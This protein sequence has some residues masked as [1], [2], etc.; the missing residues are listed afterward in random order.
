MKE[1]YYNSIVM[2]EKL[3]RLFLE[4]LK[5][6]LK[7]LNTND[8]NNIQALVLYN[9][10]EN[11]LSVG[12]LTSHGYYLGSNVSYNLRKMVENGYIMQTLND[13]DRRSSEVKLTQKG[14][15][16]YKKIDV[17]FEQHSKYLNENNIDENTIINL[18]DTLQT[19]ERYLN[20]VEIRCE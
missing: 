15:E 10:G 5:Y 1:N 2:I 6:E 19:I 7:K 13:Y 20:N 9:I 12:G 8:I 18:K 17:I 14:L 4:I 16:M 11:K 3:H